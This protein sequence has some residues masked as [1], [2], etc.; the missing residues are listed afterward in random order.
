MTSRIKFKNKD[1][2]KEYKVEVIYY[3]IVYISKSKAQL[4]DIYNLVL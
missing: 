1:N 4:L 3:N 2:N